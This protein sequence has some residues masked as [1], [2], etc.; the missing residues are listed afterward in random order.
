M[1]CSRLL[2][3]IVFLYLS[4]ISLVFAQWAGNALEFDGVN[5]YVEITHNDNLNMTEALTLDA[6]IKPAGAGITNG[7]IVMKNPLKYGLIWLPATQKLTFS[8]DIGGWADY[9]SN[10]IVPINQWSHIA[11]TYDGS[12]IRIY[13]NGV[14]D[15]EYSK[16]GSIA[17]STENLTF[18]SRLDGN[19]FFNGLIDEVR[20][21]RT[22]LSQTTLR[23]WMYKPLDSSHP[24]IADLGGY[25]PFNEGAGD[26]TIDASGNGN[27]GSLLGSVEWVAS[28]APIGAGCVYITTTS[29]AIIGP[30]GGQVR[31]TILSTPNDDNS[32]IAYQ[33]GSL[34]G[35]PSTAE[36]YP[37]GLDKRSNIV[38]GI[39]EYGDVTAN[40]VFDYSSVVGVQNSATIKLLRR[41]YAGSATWSE[42]VLTARDDVAKTFTVS[43][44]TTFGEYA[45]GAGADN[46]LQPAIP[47][48]HLIAYYPFNGNANDESGN[49][50]NA[51][52]YNATLAN[53][54]FNEPEK[55]YY[56]DGDGDYIDLGDW[57]MGGEMSIC[58]WVKYSAFNNYARVFSFANG[59]PGSGSWYY[60]CISLYNTDYDPHAIFYVVNGSTDA[61]WKSVSQE[62]F[63]SDTSWT[64]TTVVMQGA[65]LKL[66]R[67]G[68]LV[69]TNTEG[70]EPNSVTRTDQYLGH[71]NMSW[72]QWFNGLIDDLRIY[73]RALTDDE[74]ALLYNESQVPVRI[75]SEKEKIA[76]DFRLGNVYPN[77]FNATFTIPLVLSR[78]APVKL[79]LYD[80]NGKVMKV[81]ADGIRP[82]GE[83]RIAVDCSDLGSGIYLV[84][85]TI[86]EVKK[87]TKMV[88]I[89]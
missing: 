64:F 19:E 24:N 35:A 37:E 13:I 57:E 88:L 59:A 28:T 61:V 26:T 62:N 51:T 44:V 50:H 72:D 65:T 38:W 31:I 5:D 77:P 4:G 86:R 73:S 18:G 17:T 54:R 67:D 84:Q 34:A 10:S 78:T 70:Q 58:V 23:E 9:V 25:W 11:G 53:N 36:T 89:K 8:L 12:I 87:I 80:L 42:V 40:L 82:A 63:F 55:A 2:F 75:E 20:V 33:A 81:I 76:D 60:D 32:L 66:Y 46:L 43:G 69:A 83:Y 1:N 52:V 22:A 29:E 48:D 6:W 45:L 7:I 85:I 56:F 16:T 49:G 39:A 27:T 74:I 79:A 41:D 21:W 14:L 68:I 71:Q 47:N 15:T 3:R 30:L